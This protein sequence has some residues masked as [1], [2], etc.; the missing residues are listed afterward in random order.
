MAEYIS[1]AERSE[2]PQEVIPHQLR[3]DGFRFI[4]LRKKDKPAIEEGWNKDKN[5]KYD[6]P[7][8]LAHI[9]RG[10]NYGVIPSFDNLC[11]VDADD[12][13]RLNQ[14]GAIDIFSNTFTVRTGNPDAERYHYYFR[15]EGVGDVKRIPFSDP[16]ITKKHLGEIFCPGCSAYVVGPGC[17]HPS[18]RVYQVVNDVEIASINVETLDKEFFSKVKSSRTKVDDSTQ[19]ATKIPFGFN[20]SRNKLT[21]QLKLRI[22][23]LAMPI[24][25]TRR[26]NEFQGAHPVHGSTTG[27][28]FS[29]NT[30]KNVFF[31]HR[32]Q[33]GGDPITWIAVK[34]GFIRCEDAVNFP[35]EGDLFT[36]V[37]DILVSRYGYGN[38]IRKIDEEYQ[39]EKY[40][41]GY[42]SIKESELNRLKLGETI[43]F[44][45]EL[46]KDNFIEKYVTCMAK[47]TDAYLEY[48][49]ACAM[50]IL[51]ILTNRNAVM[52]LQQGTVYSN[53]WS[54]C[55]GIS[56]Y[57]K[58]STA[59]K[60]ARGLL[61]D[62]TPSNELPQ[63]YS[64]ESLVEVLSE[65]PQAWIIKDE[66]G[67]LLVAIQKKTYMSDVRDI[68]CELY[69]CNNYKRTLRKGRGGSDNSFYVDNPF[70]TQVYATTPETFRNNTELIDL[71]SGWLIRFLYF[72]PRYWKPSKPYTP[73]SDELRK[74]MG[75]IKDEMAKLF[76]VFRTSP[77]EF[78]L[79][80]D[81]LDFF[82]G[83]QLQKENELFEEGDTIKQA[84]FGRLSTYAIKLS[85]IF[86][87][88][89]PEFVKLMESKN[90]TPN[91]KEV[92][93]I[94]EKYV[95]ESC[96]QIDEYF[97][98]MGISITR[99]VERNEITSVQNK[100]L[101]TL[102]RGGGRVTR[103]AILQSLHLK[104]KDVEEHL[105]AL[106]ESGEI[107][108]VD[109]MNEETKRNTKW[110]ILTDKVN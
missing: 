67:A 12:Y 98:P 51:S 19:R 4:L 64:P 20:P 43:R 14:L 74:E 108:Q 49:Y 5:Y 102:Q 99:Q 93:E 25:A 8:L 27:K 58:K 91:E 37:K 94:E 2:N 92:I 17:I 26:G 86:K 32:C 30:V 103:K 68:F 36:K 40:G 62:L 9:A 16:V 84:I 75:Q 46:S 70:I 73:L 83:W 38:E 104:I 18:G 76:S 71:T 57:S 82:Q 54:F 110:I 41:E 106:V 22:E 66:V 31:C 61:Q 85:M 55:L 28:N 15:C 33:A 95:R 35:M 87:V 34:E 77:I 100:I 69:E 3:I 81:S 13:E 79:S 52:Y 63:S 29:I 60:F 24:N 56:T 50:S 45:S 72:S 1:L 65:T 48:H 21:D 6:D 109:V 101:G 88:G 42:I 80:S 23:D 105:Q 39:R 10:G 59:L 53:I 90:Y 96:R 89:S 7:K 47:T 97:L 11:I 78:R 107:S 44:S